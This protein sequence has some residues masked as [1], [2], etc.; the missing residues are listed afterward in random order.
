MTQIAA[1]LFSATVYAQVQKYSVSYEKQPI[2][3]VFKNLQA[4]TGYEFV[5]RNRWYR[6][7]RTSRL[8]AVT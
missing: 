6:M 4:K 8:N 2:E 3:N 7:W 1:L 5:Y